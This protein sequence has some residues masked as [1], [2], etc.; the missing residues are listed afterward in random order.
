MSKITSFEAGSSLKGPSG[1]AALSATTQSESAATSDSN[2]FFAAAHAV[3][4][5]AGLT[6][7]G[8]TCVSSLG[9]GVED[10]VLEL[11]AKVK[12]GSFL[13]I[14]NVLSAQGPS[15]LK[16]DLLL[17]LLFY[18]RSIKHGQGEKLIFYQ[19]FL[20]LAEIERFHD[21]LIDLIPFIVDPEFGC[22]KDLFKLLTALDS[23]APGAKSASLP[24]RKALMDFY[25]RNLVEGTEK[26]KSY[27]E[28]KL[29]NP[30]TKM[31]GVSPSL[32]KWAPRE[33]SEFAQLAKE[34][35]HTLFPDDA[36]PTAMKKY[37]KMLSLHTNFYTTVETL[38]CA[39]KWTEIAFE[40]VPSMAAA[41]Y[42]KAFKNV[43]K[44]GERRS[45]EWVRVSCAE[46][47]ESYLQAVASG[48]KKIN[49]KAS[50]MTEFAKDFKAAWSDDPTRE[51]QFKAYLDNMIQEAAENAK[52][53]PPGAK[54]FDMG[55]CI[56]C[57]DVSSSMDCASG[58]SG[59]TC[60][61]VAVLMGMCVSQLS[62]GPWRDKFFNFDMNPS[63]QDLSGCTSFRE[64]FQKV[65]RAKWGGS[66][67]F[68]KMMDL[69]LQIA[70]KHELTQDQLPK[71]LF[72]FSDMQFNAADGNYSSSHD[73]MVAKFKAHGYELPMIVYWNLRDAPGFPVDAS[74]PNTF[75]VSGFSPRLMKLFF[76]GGDVEK[77][78]LEGPPT[79]LK[80]MLKTLLESEGFAPI[81]AQ[82]EATRLRL[83]L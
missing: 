27:N 21:Y 29:E 19:L 60:M 33:G 8:D 11:F 2:P 31:P 41:H 45:E 22:Y 76:T 54:K 82:I 40:G 61:D 49:A 69:I 52:T 5:R 37:R 75:M 62:S 71:C 39:G 47:Y 65:Y 43:T 1:V 55:A 57:I 9:Q 24:V 18:V 58:A 12:R 51:L 14:L 35:A 20:Q 28:A 83:T 74:T 16:Q 30:E 80:M 48:E 73:S 34:I 70:N 23:S 15:E 42:R 44:K 32:G 72:V 25:I 66:T 7:N 59:C 46:L 4:S 53:L 77:L 6:E 36:H 56:A 63:L 67:D 81:R 3:I 17:I 50:L 10:Q 26:I 78:L 64:K 38:M 68:R 79:P 13:S